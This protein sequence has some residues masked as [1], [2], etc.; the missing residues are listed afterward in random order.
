[1]IGY[2]PNDRLKRRGYWSLVVGRLLVKISAAIGGC[3]LAV[4]HQAKKPGLSVLGGRRPV[5]SAVGGS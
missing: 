2:W 3:F 5:E 1:M 4:G